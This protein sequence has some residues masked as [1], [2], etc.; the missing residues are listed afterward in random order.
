MIFIESMK[1]LA[2]M[3]SRKVQ[4]MS[5][6]HSGFPQGHCFIHVVRSFNDDILRSRKRAESLNDKVAFYFIALPQNP[7][8]LE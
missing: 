3:T 4:R 8:C 7:F 2:P 1:L 5:K 6:V